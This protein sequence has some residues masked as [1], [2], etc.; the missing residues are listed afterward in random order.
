[1]PAAPQWPGHVPAAPTA[2][3]QPAPAGG[4]DYGQGQFQQAPPSGL[5][6]GRAAARARFGKTNSN[7]QAA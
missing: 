6:A 3:G 5:E 2:P 4:P 7:S 1:V